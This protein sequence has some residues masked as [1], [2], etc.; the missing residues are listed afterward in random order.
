M[1]DIADHKDGIASPP[2]YYEMTP[3]EKQT[4]W[5]KKLNYIWFNMPEKRKKYFIAN[6][7]FKFQ[8]FWVHKG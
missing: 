4:L 5:F 2:D 8:W 6:P 7:S 1:K 3:A